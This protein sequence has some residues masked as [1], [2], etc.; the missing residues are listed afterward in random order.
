MNPSFLKKLALPIFLGAFGAI[1]YAVLLPEVSPRAAIDM[2]F[3]RKEIMEQGRHYLLGLG[4]DLGDYQ[5]DAWMEFEWSTDIFL[6]T[7]NGMRVANEMLRADSLPVH[8]WL[9]SWYDRDVPQSQNPETFR[10]WVSPGGRILGFDHLIKDSVTR[11]SY[12]ND[13]ARIL[14]EQFLKAQGIDL[15]PYHLKNFSD[16]K[17]VG[18]ID[19]HFVWTKADTGEERSIW[20]RVQGREVGGFRMTLSPSEDFERR[21]SQIATTATFVATASFAG[22]F[23]LFFFIVILFLKK[24]HEGE[25]G[26]KT[27]M[28]VFFGL[29]VLALLSSINRYPVIGSDT[30]MGDLN[31][32]NVRIVMFVMDVFILQAFVCVMVFAAWSV[33]ESSSR[34]TWPAKLAGVDSALHRRFFTEDLADGIFR[35]YAWGLIIVGAYSGLMYLMVTRMGVR[36][37]GATVTGGVVEAYIPA[38]QPV[39]AGIFTAVFAEVIF[40][41]FFVSFLRE[42][43]KRAWPGVLISALLWSVAAFTMWDLP[44]G[45]I[46]IQYSVIALFVFGLLF[47]LL[48]LKYDLV[49][50]LSANFI[51]GALNS[52][53]PIMVSTGAYFKAE[54]EALVVLLALPLLVATVGAIRRKRFV[55]TPATLPG[56]IQRISE[57][58]RMAKELEIARSVQMSLLPKSDPKA[59]GYDIA[60]ICIPAQEVG[61]DYYDFVSLGGRKI[62]IAIGDV[63]GKGVPA[64]IY[65]TLTKGILQSHAEDNVSPKS[66]LSKVNSLMYKTIERNSFVSMFYA[67]LDLERRTIRFA[68]A[69]QCP[70]I[71]TQSAGGAGSFLTPKGMALGLEMGKVFDSVLEEQEISL[72]SGEVLVFYT[73]GF[74]EAMNIREEEFGEDRLVAAIARHREQPAHAMIQNLCEEVRVFAGDRP[75]HDD[76]TMVVVK[77]G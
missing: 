22:M 15:S 18:R 43:L 46:D 32:F 47:S 55:F 57:R 62:G 24:Y 50:T 2:K 48:F 10:I 44:F 16:T 52:A 72:K 56:H 61:G 63:S 25:V 71:L 58:V 26:T 29:F 39:M 38:L 13:E 3:S 7:R 12:S 4:F 70:I 34:I 27:A 23:L 59:E 1:V 36:V 6:Q 45:F 40:R 33:G 76:M 67:I 68:R 37:Y 73:D 64:A 35:G 14:A 20:V 54:R 17:Q 65:M 53:T 51:M 66:V 8:H 77:V 11:D 75:Q 69:G 74:T 5:Q 49:T 30:G 28:M 9:L 60:G 19:Y 41:L 42:K 21:S 31:K